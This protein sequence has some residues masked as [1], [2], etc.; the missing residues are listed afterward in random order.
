MIIGTAGHIDHGKSALVTALTGRSMDRL[1]EERRRGITID[2][3]FAPLRF[4]GLPPAGIVDVPGHEDF[5]RTMVAGASGIDLVLLV[6]DAGQGPQPQ[7]WEHLAIVEQLRIPRGI[8]VI[9]KSDLADPDWIELVTAEVVTRLA[10]SPVAFEAP[11]IVSAV[12]GQGIPELSARLRELVQSYRRK[13]GSDEFRMPIDR[14]FSIAGVGTVVTGTPWS[15]T[16]KTGDIVTILPGGL[17]ARVRS[18]EAYGDAVDAGRPGS[19]TAVGLVGVGKSAVGRGNTLVGAGGS[20]RSTTA[21]DVL[22]DLLPDAPPV[23][24]RLRV[25]LHLGTAE[26]LGR[27]HPRGE[28]GPGGHGAARLALEAPVV[29]RGSDRF[30]LRSYS[31]VVTIGGGRVLDPLPPLRASWPDGLTSSSSDDRLGALITRRPTGVSVGELPLLIGLPPALSRK[32]AESCKEVTE[33]GGRYIARAATVALRQAAI[34]LVQAFHQ[35]EPAERGMS[36]ETLRKALRGP[37]EVTSAVLHGVVRRGE[38]VLTDGLASFPGFIPRLAQGEEQMEKALELLEAAGLEPPT[39]AELEER[40]GVRGLLQTLRFAVQ[41]GRAVAVESDRYFSPSALKQFG[42]T[43]RELATISPV[44]PPMV[45]DRLGLSRK[46]LI[47]LLEW[48]DRAGI[49]RRVGDARVLV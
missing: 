24:R 33:V 47:P 32:Q 2:L 20:W 34:A 10:A 9:T 41:Q 17:T 3:N 48:S 18:L 31:P 14:A 38:L 43:I 35:R 49:T 8:L 26:V 16:L 29:A 12:T 25:R 11:A 36:L 21:L 40:L 37:A 27:L 15:G 30:V 19:R 7:T 1:A 22:I 6:V 46:Y 13:D 42:D 44:T 4:E 45:R 39:V 28:I 5:V 23:R